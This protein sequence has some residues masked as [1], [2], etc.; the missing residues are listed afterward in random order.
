MKKKKEEEEIYKLSPKYLLKWCLSDIGIELDDSKLDALWII[1]EARM[2]NFGYV[3][4]EE[5]K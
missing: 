1:F 4:K 2:E 5:R 3:K